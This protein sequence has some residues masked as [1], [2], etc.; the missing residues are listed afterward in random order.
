M[1]SLKAPFRAEQVGSLPRPERL[2][3]ARDDFAAKKISRTELAKIEDESIRVAV[4]MQE[5]SPGSARSRTANFAN[6]A[7]ASFSMTN[8]MDLDRRQLSAHFHLRHST[9]RSFLRALSQR[10]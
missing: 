6:A 4:A 8:A 2:M 10:S 5:R 3:A 1:A 7:G 9:A